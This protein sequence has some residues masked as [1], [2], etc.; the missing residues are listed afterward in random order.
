MVKVKFEATKFYVMMAVTTS[1]VL[2]ILLFS[3]KTSQT[4]RFAQL[5][6]KK[7]PGVETTFTPVIDYI[8][9][10]ETPV[11]TPTRKPSL[12]PTNNPKSI[13]MVNME[14]LMEKYAKKESVNRELLKKI[15]IC[16]SK[17]NPAALNGTYG[18]LYQFTPGAWTNNRKEM[19]SDP[20]PDL[21]F[22]PEEAIRTAAY[23][24]SRG[25]VYLW[26]NCSK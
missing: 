1:L 16:E 17:L 20:N 19:N 7:S 22:I 15:A 23:A 18:G 6:E 2:S 13:T 12:T 9:I 14:D 25:R 4:G 24:V 8:V 5:S 26:P 11:A 3:Q 21:R 10:T